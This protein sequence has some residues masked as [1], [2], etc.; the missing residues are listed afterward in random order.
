MSMSEPRTPDDTLP[1]GTMLVERYRIGS[2]LGRGGFGITYRA[3]DS[4]LQRFVAI[5]EMFPDGS[6]RSGL[7]V[8]LSH[9]LQHS[10]GEAHDEFM[11]EA[12]TLARLRDPAIVHVYEA[13][14]S[15]DTVFVVMEFLEGQTYHELLNAEGPLS[16]A[17][18]TEVLRTVGNALRRVHA[19]GFAHRDI[20]PANIMCT[21]GR[22]ILID[23][24][25]ARS[26][27]A[28]KSQDLSRLVT[29]G[30]SPL[31][32]YGGHIRFASRVDV[33]ALAAT[34]YTL[35][36]GK[37]PVNAADRA[38]G[39][40]LPTIAELV[41][42]APFALHEAILAG[43]T[44]PADQRP[45]MDT[46]L[47]MLPD[48]SVLARSASSPPGKTSPDTPPP[49]ELIATPAATSRLSTHETIRVD[50]YALDATPSTRSSLSPESPSSP[51]LP[52]SDSNISKRKSLPI[53]GAVALIVAVIAGAA[54]AIRSASKKSA[55]PSGA[56]STADSAVVSR[57]TRQVDTST[58]VFDSTG[59]A[60]SS[61]SNAT[62]TTTAVVLRP[63][64]V[65]SSA[66]RKPVNLRCTGE[67][68]TYDAKNLFDGDVQTGWGASAA[69][70]A[71]Q[72]VTVTFAKPVRLRRIAMTPGFL[73]D[74]PRKDEDCAMVNAF[75]YNR[76]VSEVV[77][78]FDSASIPQKFQ[79]D[80][81]PQSIDVDVITTKVTMRIVSTDR[82]GIDN[83]TIISELT[84]YGDVS[85]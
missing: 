77:Y 60:S 16:A 11:R 55:A 17:N 32:Q 22:P 38:Q 27:V 21:D 23:F 31:E 71:G 29:P 9:R 35:V 13:L 51:R 75:P 14:E 10:A 5:K 62:N 30:Y 50:G 12:M 58:T 64:N 18:A 3:F 2:V 1:A 37:M 78:I 76:F 48:A 25:A 83:D 49:T 43:M 67:R 68:V 44:M 34:G 15:F 56:N 66:A 41:P 70:G 73:R 69:D 46:F 20:K 85:Q 81:S 47:A 36:T 72:T 79:F 53:V 7:S 82:K 8:R 39:I 57:D 45:E 4:H 61:A 59:S 84:F 24:G 33:Y 52:I 19:Q 80:P 26:F 74:A 65:T 6:T 28:E 40:R 42:S 63:V 54:F